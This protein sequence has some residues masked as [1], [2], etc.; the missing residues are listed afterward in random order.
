MDDGDLFGVIVVV[1]SGRI[2][3]ESVCIVTL[4]S[5]IGGDVVTCCDV[6]DVIEEK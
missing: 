1:F 5:E 3:L 6:W 2:L 4:S